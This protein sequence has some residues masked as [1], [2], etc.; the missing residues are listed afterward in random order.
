VQSRSNFGTKKLSFINTKYNLNSYF[1]AFKF[2]STKKGFAVGGDLSGEL[3]FITRLF[4]IKEEVSTWTV[5]LWI[6]ST[7]TFPYGSEAREEKSYLVGATYSSL[8]IQIQ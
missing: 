1:L 2:V 6:A 3:G 4:Q 8:I 7:S 5:I